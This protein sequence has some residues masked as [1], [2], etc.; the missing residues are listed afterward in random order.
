[1]VMKQFLAL[2]DLDASEVQSTDPFALQLDLTA[3]AEADAQ[4][5]ALSDEVRTATG[6]VISLEAIAHYLRT[7]VTPCALGASGA[8]FANLAIESICLES[9][10]PTG[11]LTFSLEAYHADPQHAMACALE[12]ILEKIKNAWAFIK[13]KVVS[14]FRWIGEKMDYFKRNMRNLTGKLKELEHKLSAVQGGTAPQRGA[15]KP[16]QKFVNLIY[17]EKGFVDHASSVTKDVNA[18]LFEHAQLF[19]SVIAKHVGWLK[20]H[21]AAAREDISEFNTLHVNRNDFLMLDAQESDRTIETRMPQEGNMFYRSRELPGGMAIY[22]EIQ[23]ADQSGVLAIEMLGNIQV[24]IAPFDP[25]S[26]DVRAL[27]V[28]EQAQQKMDDWY[29]SLPQEVRVNT[30]YPPEAD[31][32]KARI[33]GTGREVYIHP[34]MIFATLPLAEAKQRL[35]ELRKTVDHLQDWYDT[36]FGQIWKDKGFDYLASS[37]ID[38]GESRQSGTYANPSVKYLASLAWSLIA[39]MGNATEETH[40]YV[41]ETCFSL[42]SYVEKSLV[43][44]TVP[45]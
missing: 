12:S 37:L 24:H 11:A 17:L 35:A 13:E 28:L 31:Y 32:E 25:A 26:Y 43:Q 5:A 42:L 41:F 20:D 34:D 39:L 14:F 21:H 7:A 22:T 1:M 19:S 6:A 40:V 30:P 15:L 45:K 8:Q 4:G 2:E 44:Y 38:K 9:H 10:L 36:V 16:D 3:L 33:L 29:D 18:L 27:Q 23:K